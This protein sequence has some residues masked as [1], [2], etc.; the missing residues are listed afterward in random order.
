MLNELHITRASAIINP[1]SHTE[2]CVLAEDG[3]KYHI[4]AYYSE[5]DEPLSIASSLLCQSILTQWK[6]KS[7]S[8]AGIH[9]HPELLKPYRPEFNERNIYTGYR[10]EKGLIWMSPLLDDGHYW[11]FKA[12]KN[13]DHLL[14]FGLFDLWILNSSRS[15]AKPNIL[16]K[17]CRDGKLELIP[18]HHHGLL[19]N[20]IHL[21]WNRNHSLSQV[22]FIFDLT[23]VKKTFYHLRKKKARKDWY[24]D[25]QTSITST[26]E[27]YT[28]TIRSISDIAKVEKTLWNQLYIFLFD[29][30]RNEVVFNHFWNLMKR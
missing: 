27:Q 6:L 5:K 10:S 30:N 7:I 25:F 8:M 28:D 11:S 21:E 23:L 18:I 2:L 4:R 24:E 22:S 1:I 15:M 19:Q 16:L 12:L 3:H 17:P 29:N 13:P 20:L 26:R 14:M 9:L